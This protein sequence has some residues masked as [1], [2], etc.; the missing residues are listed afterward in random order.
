M[1]IEQIHL[2]VYLF[3]VISSIC[4]G[5]GLCRRVL[6]TG[7]GWEKSRRNNLQHN[8]IPSYAVYQVNCYASTYKHIFIYI[9][10]VALEE[11][12]VEWVCAVEFQ[13][14]RLFIYFF[15]EKWMEEHEYCMCH[16]DAGVNKVLGST[17]CL[18]ACAC[19]RRCV[20]ESTGVLRPLALN[21]TVILGPGWGWLART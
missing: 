10:A 17:V 11:L 8:V 21:Q 6:E 20:C 16:E 15:F 2:S 7:M 9:Y 3:G 13:L 5:D 18:I 1:D 12:S 19:G 4:V 14:L